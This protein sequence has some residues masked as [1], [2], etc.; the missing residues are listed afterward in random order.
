MAD[1]DKDIGIEDIFVNYKNLKGA[2]GPTTTTL[3]E[4]VVD[5]ALA[6]GGQRAWAVQ[7][8]EPFISIEQ[9]V[10]EELVKATADANNC[11][12]VGVGRPGLAAIGEPY[13]PPPP[14]L[15]CRWDFGAAFHFT[16]SGVGMVTYEQPRVWRPATAVPYARNKMSL[17]CI[18]TNALASLNDMPQAVRVSYTYI[19]VTD[20]LYREINERWAL[21]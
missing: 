21:D 3:K 9:L 17:Y 1:K 12:Q 18:L 6:I 13:E 20:R 19:P 16:T 15:L 10:Q 4:T 2:L 11:L 14:G 8:I 7:E 5:T